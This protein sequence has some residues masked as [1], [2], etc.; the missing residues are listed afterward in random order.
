MGAFEGKVDIDGTGVVDVV[1]TGV[2]DVELRLTFILMLKLILLIP[3]SV[4]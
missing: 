1:G 4:V 3:L 2:A